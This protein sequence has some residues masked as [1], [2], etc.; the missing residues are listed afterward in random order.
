MKKLNRIKLV[1]IISTTGLISACQTL[2]QNNSHDT[3]I[4]QLNLQDTSWTQQE[5][6]G[7]SSDFINNGW[8]SNLNDSRLNEYIDIALK[9][10]FSLQRSQKQVAA[11]LRQTRINTAALWPSINLNIRKNR[12]QTET[13]TSS[14]VMSQVNTTSVFSGN[15]GIS[16]ELDLWQKLSSKKKSSISEAKASELDFDAAKLS[17][18]ATVARAWFSINELKLNLDI[19]SQRLQTIQ[20]SLSVV[21]EQYTSGQQSALNVYLNRID[22]LNQ[23]NSVSN[24]KGRLEST[25]RDFKVLLGQYPN[26]ELDF[27]ASLPSISKNVPA[28]LPAELISRRAD[29]KASMLRWQSK[30]Y[31]ARNAQLSRLPSFSLTANYGASSDELKT[32]DEKTLLWNI[33]NNLTLPLFNGGQL[34]AQADAAEL[35][36]DAEFN[37]YLSTILNS[38]NEVETA[39]SNEKSIQKQIERLAEIVVLAESG[40]ALAKEQYSSGLINYTDLLSSQRRWFDAQSRLTSLKNSALQNRI[41]LNIALGGDFHSPESSTNKPQSKTQ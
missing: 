29:V 5:N 40:Y 16:W 28:G 34:K 20:D 7:A 41:A 19:E 17:L 11:K 39:L 24:L 2:P 4:E 3:V 15:L 26:I 21:E 31:S 8:L 36:K 10:N 33:V 25:I 37:D 14:G 13:A 30:E 12:N 9:N 22:A 23:Q 27:N 6:N 18:V 35:L 32:L 38:F 1:T